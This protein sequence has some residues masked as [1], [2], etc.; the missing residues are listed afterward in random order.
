MREGSTWSAN[1]GPSAGVGGSGPYVYA[2][3]SSP[4]VQGDLFTLAYDGSRCIAGPR[5]YTS[6]RQLLPLDNPQDTTRTVGHAPGASA[7]L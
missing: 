7:I 6:A 3:A 5:G 1:T 4:R 2:E